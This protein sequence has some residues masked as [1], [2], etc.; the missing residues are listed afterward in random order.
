MTNLVTRSL[1][2]E[3]VTVRA[4]VHDALFR[5]VTD[6]WLAVYENQYALMGNAR[7]MV[8][9]VIWDTAFYWGVFGL[10]FFQDR[11]RT[12]A[13]TPS[14]AADLERLTDI[15]NRVQ[16]FFREWAAL[17]DSR[18]DPRF[19]DLYSPLDFMVRLH[20]GMADD[21]TDATFPSVSRP[22]PGSSPNWPGNWSP[23]SSTPTATGTATTG[24]WPRS[25]AGSGTR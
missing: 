6:M 21:L 10:L 23:R 11:F 19:V 18:L 4:S 16:A 22:T 24:S 14:V 13:D 12:V 3:D 17:D 8:S 1:D 7:V 5:R 9:K 25:R 20:A 2:G 15:S